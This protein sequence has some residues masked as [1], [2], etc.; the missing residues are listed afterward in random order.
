MEPPVQ[1][2]QCAESNN[3]DELFCFFASFLELTVKEWESQL[4]A[5]VQGT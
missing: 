3:F 2:K 1:R 4:R 5:G